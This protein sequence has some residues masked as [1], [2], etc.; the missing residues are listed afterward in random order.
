V[1]VAMALAVIGVLGLAASGVQ[2]FFE[3][4]PREG[5]LYREAVVG[6]PQL[7]NPLYAPANEVDTDISRLIF[8]GLLRY[9][10]HGV[11]VPD[12]A[13]SYEINEE[14]TEYTFLLRSDA[15]WH[16]G[17]PLTINDVLFTYGAIQDPVYASPLRVS[18]QGV[19]IAA[20]D[21]T[22]IQFVLEKPFAPFLGSLTAGIIPEHIWANID[23]RNARLSPFNLKPVGSGPFQFR[24]NAGS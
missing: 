12:V 8:S 7:I 6:A 9:D 17:T 24:N 10:E 19:T 22:R 1:H 11:L 23:P 20:L 3:E 5:G 14:Q 13:L 15:I 18:F 21:D 2:T 16:D 4:V